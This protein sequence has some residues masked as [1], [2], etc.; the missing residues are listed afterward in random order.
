MIGAHK[1]SV[2][3]YTIVTMHWARIGWDFYT[4]QPLISLN[5]VHKGSIENKP[6]LVLIKKSC[7]TGDKTII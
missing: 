7:P 1:T 4:K 5:L 3:A 2:Y 6:A